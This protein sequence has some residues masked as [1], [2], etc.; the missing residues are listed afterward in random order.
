MKYAFKQN[1]AVSSLYFYKI[2]H[3]FDVYH[4]KFKLNTY[5]IYTLL[6]LKPLIKFLNLYKKI[7]NIS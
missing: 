3:V 6:H 2:I 1:S 5:K 7:K 4:Q